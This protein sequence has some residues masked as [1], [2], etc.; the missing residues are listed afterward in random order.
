MS[1]KK[2]TWSYILLSLLLIGAYVFGNWM[3]TERAYGDIKRRNK[4]IQL[5]IDLIK[6]LIPE[7]KK[8]KERL[9]ELLE[10]IEREIKWSMLWNKETTGPRP[11]KRVKPGEEDK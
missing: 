9:I 6:S 5:D 11:S 7:T 4:K 3:G 10:N 1:A 2:R 8:D